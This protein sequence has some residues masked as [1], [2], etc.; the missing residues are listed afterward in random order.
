[1]LR[2]AMLGNARRLGG[3]VFAATALLFAM[4]L[5]SRDQIRANERQVMIAQL[6]SVLAA[7]HYDNDILAG[8]TRLHAEAATGVATP[9]P[10]YRASQGKRVVALVFTVVA[11]DGYGGPI[12]LLIG[13]K[14]DGEIL[15]VRVIA[16]QETPGLGD[17]IEIK[18][19][20]WVTQFDSQ[21]LSRTQA[22]DWKVK[23]D[24]G[25]FDQM[26]GATITPRAVVKAVRALLL[27]FRMHKTQLLAEPE[28]KQETYHAR[29]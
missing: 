11:P 1:M 8:M 9:M 15:A 29:L 10:Y 2:S 23:K 20:P 14:P 19:S 12:T 4:F 21:S 17:G 13:V 16:H 3:F 22:S 5:F 24:G 18:K 26:T 28:S 6:N 7:V 27:Y 25:R